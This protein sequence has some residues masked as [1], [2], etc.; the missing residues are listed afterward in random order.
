MNVLYYYYYLFYKKSSL[1]GEPEFTA[2]LALT[3]SEAL[4]L[5]AIIDIGVAYFWGV[6]LNKAWMIAIT[7]LV[8]FLNLFFLLPKQKV[9]NIIKNKPKFFESHRLS[10]I[11]CWLFFLL[12]TSTLFWGGYVAN[13]IISVHAK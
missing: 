1:D 6:L 13:Y 2:K 7:L 10:I 3:A 4:F 9:I 12:T 5:I 8:L 11:F